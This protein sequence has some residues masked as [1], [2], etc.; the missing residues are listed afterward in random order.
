[1]VNWLRSEASTYCCTLV[2]TSC[3]TLGTRGEGGDSAAPGHPGL[4]LVPAVLPHGLRGLAPGLLSPPAAPVPVHQLVVA[5]HDGPQGA[6]QVGEGGQ[7]G[8]HGHGAAELWVGRR[9]GARSHQAHV[10]V[11]HGPAVVVDC[12]GEMHQDLPEGEIRANV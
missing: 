3:H 9:T 4:Q 7:E 6:Q 5:A 11:H 1:M 12:R 2:W 8:G 10:P